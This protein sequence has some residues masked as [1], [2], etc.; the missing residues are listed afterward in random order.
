MFVVAVRVSA[1]GSLGFNS[2]VS[3]YQYAFERC[4]A[5]ASAVGHESLGKG[6]NDCAR[7]PA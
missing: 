4:V 2:P 7:L 6:D 5:A 3:K 1:D